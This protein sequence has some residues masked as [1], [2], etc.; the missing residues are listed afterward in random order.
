VPAAITSVKGKKYQ[1][2]T[3]AGSDW[4]KDEAANKGFYCLKFMMQDP[5]YYEYNY[6]S[7]G[8]VTVP[9]MGTKF[10]ATAN[11]DL[12]G[13]GI[14]STFLVLGAVSNNALY[15]GPN[16]SETDPEE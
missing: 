4:G 15:V 13:D 14:L 1:A 7:D 8:D 2:N 5:Q 11:G 6:I 3:A 10:T 16:I 9:T 12:N